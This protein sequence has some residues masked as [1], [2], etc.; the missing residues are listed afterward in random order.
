MFLKYLCA[1][2]YLIGRFKILTE[3]YTNFLPTLVLL[4]TNDLDS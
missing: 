1:I 3:V 2:M 4:L